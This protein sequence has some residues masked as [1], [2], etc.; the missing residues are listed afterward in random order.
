LLFVTAIECVWRVKDSSA[1]IGDE[2]N[3]DGYHHLLKFSLFRL[4][5]LVLR[6][7]GILTL[8]ALGDIPF[9]KIRENQG[10]KDWLRAFSAVL[11]SW[12]EIHCTASTS[13]GLG[14]TVP[15]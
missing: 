5:G 1:G 7:Q 15:E 13:A 3:L 14:V 4:S 11:R 2:D 9:D 10:V 6:L 8:P 12:E